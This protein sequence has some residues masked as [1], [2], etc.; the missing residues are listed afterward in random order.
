M[1]QDAALTDLL[2]AARHRHSAAFPARA[3]DVLRTMAAAAHAESLRRT[4]KFRRTSCSVV[5]YR[6][7]ARK[8]TAV[9]LR[10][11]YSDARCKALSGR[12]LWGVKWAAA[13]S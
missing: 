1:Q 5:G 11:G 3:A 13:V 2:Q 10:S 9:G 4:Q 6:T 12:L 8:F 7:D